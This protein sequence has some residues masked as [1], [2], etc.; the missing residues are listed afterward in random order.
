MVET[1]FNYCEVAVA[2]I[3]ETVSNRFFMLNSKTEEE[4]VKLEVK[5]NNF[6]LVQDEE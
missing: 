6:T 3:R 5:M 1:V 2:D 4:L